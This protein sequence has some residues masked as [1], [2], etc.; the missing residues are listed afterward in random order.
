MLVNLSVPGCCSP[1]LEK[2]ILIFFLITDPFFLI[3]MLEED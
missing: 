2:A 1:F 3:I